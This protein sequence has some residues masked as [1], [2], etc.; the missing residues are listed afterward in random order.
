LLKA[1]TQ[2]YFKGAQTLTLTAHAHKSTDDKTHNQQTEFTNLHAVDYESKLKNYDACDEFPNLARTYIVKSMFRDLL[3]P[4]HGHDEIIEN[5]YSQYMVGV[6]KAPNTV[7]RDSTG[8]IADSY[9]K[10]DLPDKPILH[11][12]SDFEP[13][14][15]DFKIDA[16]TDLNLMRGAHS[17]G[18][19]F[20]VSG[21]NPAIKLCC[22]WGTY[23]S[24][25]SGLYRRKTNLIVSKPIAISERTSQLDPSS[26]DIIHVH[27]PTAKIYMYARPIHDTNRWNVSVFL[28]NN[29][30][31]TKQK[32]TTNNNSESI[33]QPQIRVLCMSG[34]SLE[35]LEGSDTSTTLFQ[36]KNSKG[37]G[38]LC[39]VV[40]KDVDP[41]HDPTHSEFFDVMWPDSMSSTV[42]PK[43]RETFSCPDIRTEY[44]PMYSILQPDTLAESE[45]KAT[46]L[47]ELWE[48]K[49]IESA[50]NPIV[51]NYK[52]WIEA[53]QNELPPHLKQRATKQMLECTNCANRIQ[54]GIDLLLD[55]EKARLAFCFMNRTIDLKNQWD[56]KHGNGFSW[57]T[58][59]IAFI[60]QTLPGLIIPGDQAEKQMCDILWFPTGG[61]KTEA[62][63]GLMLFSFAYRRLCN[64][65][66]FEMDGGVSVISRYTLRLLT[67]QQFS[68]TLGMILAAELLRVQN[69][70]PSTAKFTRNDLTTKN[71]TGCIWGQTRFSLGLWIGDLTPNRFH[72][73]KRF[74]YAEGALLPKQPYTE[75]NGEPA[76][77]HKCPCCNSTLAIPS[78][79]ST[80]SNATHT[81]TWIIKSDRSLSQLEAIPDKDFNS[82]L[83]TICKNGDSP[84][85][86]FTLINKS[87]AYSYYALR[88]HFKT[89]RLSSDDVDNWWRDHV[90]KSL[91]VDQDPLESTK[92]SRPGYFFLY[93]K[94][95]RYDFVIHCPNPNCA[96]WVEWSESTPTNSSPLIAAPFI[97]PDC[98]TTSI[99][100][101]IPAFTIDTQVYGRCPTVVIA[102]TDKFARLP[103]KPDAASIF[104]NVDTYHALHGFRRETVSGTDNETV[105][106]PRFYPPSLIIQDELH[107]IEGPL[108][109]MVGLYE[110]AIDA[111]SSPGGH[112]PKYVASTATVKEATGQVGMIYRRTA[113]VFPPHGIFDGK[114][115]FSYID[116]D[117]TCTANKPGRLYVGLLVTRG[118][119]LGLVKI[120]ASVLSSVY[121]RKIAGKRNGV[122]DVDPYWTL[123]G[124]Y[125]AIREL[126]IA[127]NLYNSDILRDVQKLSSTEYFSTPQKTHSKTFS[128]LTRFIPIHIDQNLALESLTVHCSNDKGKISLALYDCDPK[129]KKPTA[130]LSAVRGSQL[131]TIHKGSNIFPLSNTIKTNRTMVYVALHNYSNETEF[132]CGSKLTSYT[133]DDFDF[134]NNLIIFDKPKR[135]IETTT[136]LKVGVRTAH[137]DLVPTK[138]VELSSSVPSSD[139]PQIMEDLETPKHIDALF[140]TSIF[141]TGVDIDRLGLMIV[142][143]QPKSTSSYIQA[144]GRIGRQHPGLVITWLRATR[145]RDLSHYEN[146]VGYHRAI[147]QY[148]EPI[149]SA[150]FSEKALKTCLGPVL[151]AILR[152]ARQINTADVPDKWIDD[153]S[154]MIN[155]HKSAEIE[156]LKTHITKIYA[157]LTASKKLQ[158]SHEEFNE[159]FDHSILLWHELAMLV[160]DNRKGER[161]EYDE[162]TLTKIENHVVLG[163]RHHEVAKKVCVY[164]R[165]HNSLRDVESTFTLGEQDLVNYD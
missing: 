3:G 34:T 46:E 155:N 126:A 138:S 50:L 6:L 161:L 90:K 62:Y 83:F 73:R 33:F 163:T 158:L 125:N 24:P 47:S 111:L 16:D 106:V 79:K 144:T 45:F 92:A 95:A 2:E 116:E 8:T 152:N 60:L 159:I 1:C 97:K 86:S 130:V 48:P 43:I 127:R 10:A 114:N 134:K 129:T 81:I 153:P 15:T 87:G 23:E 101:P 19:S 78:T 31:Y 13:D 59:Q 36:N 165:V 82:R 150:P 109:S 12:D 71:N 140:T 61:G 9:E 105:A 18:L 103:F 123:V 160:S 100:T 120:Y 67:L 93:R 96:T 49:L 28:V 41:G 148:V 122:D 141:G 4:K 143:G 52:Q 121:R 94:N 117:N 53:Q 17:L 139:L 55:D 112:K 146:F 72:Q 25:N 66:L 7:S 108:G 136:T 91:K 113:R 149:S 44:L 151:V 137:R 14:D 69:W 68:R 135:V 88:V 119:L 107:L 74:L 133:S 98:P 102:T 38:H 29:A 26:Y 77:I 142:A 147:N 80:K 104:G 58:F 30:L 39:G 32:Q 27:G 154:Y 37:R 57:R 75:S 22:T 11:K 65:N 63:M 131:K 21:D 124:Y 84:A 115:H 145:V 85:K 110:L 20:I 76:Q 42:P 54:R 5:P 35:D 64:D 51:T 128:P 40:W 156:S 89:L 56:S 132:D 70:R 162:P 164:K 157:E 118:M 99:N